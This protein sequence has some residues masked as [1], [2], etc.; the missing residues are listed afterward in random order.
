MGS[1]LLHAFKKGGGINQESYFNI[2]HS[3]ST[4]LCPFKIF[5]FAIAKREVIPLPLSFVPFHHIEHTRGHEIN[6]RHNHPVA[7]AQQRGKG[8]SFHR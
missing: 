4:F 8:S 6:K 1:P 2:S 7:D 3:S 5:C